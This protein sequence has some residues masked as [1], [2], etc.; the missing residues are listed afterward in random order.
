[1]GRT[2]F[3]PVTSSVSGKRSPAELTARET[4]RR[5]RES[6]PCTGLC[7]PLPKPLGHSAARVPDL[8][9]PRHRRAVVTRQLARRDPAP[10]SG[11]RDSNPRPS[12][13][14]GD[15]LPAA[16]RPHPPAGPACVQNFSRSGP[17]F[18]LTSAHRG[19]AACTFRPV[20]KDCRDSVASCPK[21]PRAPFLSPVSR[22]R[23]R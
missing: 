6:N 19:T 2:G 21:P 3:E 17:S 7:R 20:T 23:P 4:A 14:Q 22:P 18:K 16:L 13:W 1:V 15:A 11:R 9:H 8:R 10:P 12:P 5:R